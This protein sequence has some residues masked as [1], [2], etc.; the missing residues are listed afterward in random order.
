MEIDGD[1]AANGYAL[2]RRCVAPDV[3]QSLLRQIQRDTKVRF[4]PND[5][6]S[7]PILARRTWEIYGRDYPPLDAFLWGVTGTM[8]AITGRSLVPTYDYFRLYA[9]GDICRVHRDRA[10]CEHSLSLTLA[11]SDG[12]AW[13]LEIGTSGSARA[14]EKI[15]GDFGDEPVAAMEMAAGDAVAYRG[16]EHR[17]ARTIPNPNRWSAHV[18]MHWVE[19]DGPHAGQAFD[20]KVDTSEV[21]FTFFDRP[22]SA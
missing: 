9:A 6:G 10:A 3:A 2:I 7:T 16:T 18:F 12:L 5:G 4:V 17:H 8:E 14:A 15:S 13:P 22:T 19:R 1:Y 20:G 21:D 11:Y